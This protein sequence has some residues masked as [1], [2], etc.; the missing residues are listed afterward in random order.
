MASRAAPKYVVTSRSVDCPMCLDIAAQAET[1]WLPVIHTADS[2]S[3]DS[4]IWWASVR[5]DRPL[6]D[7][8]RDPEG[9][10]R[11]RS[12]RTAAGHL[13]E[14]VARA[15][16]AEVISVRGDVLSHSGNLIEPGSGKDVTVLVRRVMA[17]VD[18]C[19][20]DS[21]C[22]EVLCGPDRSGA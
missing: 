10:K 5:G 15:P 9:Y 8:L 4:R 6:L 18:A 7:W 17:G 21:V 22:A 11:A 20:G 16:V 3:P 14:L 12:H 13:A 19:K 1:T 2:T